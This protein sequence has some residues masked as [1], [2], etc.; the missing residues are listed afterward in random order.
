MLPSTCA[1]PSTCSNGS[2]ILL[3]PHAPAST[4]PGIPGP[5][6]MVT[7]RRAENPALL[8]NG[9]QAARNSVA[10]WGR[11]RCS[12]SRP[13]EGGQPVEEQDHGRHDH[14]QAKGG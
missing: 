4:H 11:S 3:L 9:L 6:R 13:I 7:E 2:A 1:T 10:R 5:A 8:S 14:V 12:G